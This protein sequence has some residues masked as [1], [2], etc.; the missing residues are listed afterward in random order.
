MFFTILTKRFD[1]ELKM[2]TLIE[3]SQT[4]LLNREP[5]DVET[6]LLLLETIQNTTCLHAI[7]LHQNYGSDLGNPISQYKKSSVVV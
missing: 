1:F 2:L 4:H 3:S 5:L 7:T 6:V